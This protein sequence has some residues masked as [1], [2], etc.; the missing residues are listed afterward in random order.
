VFLTT[1]EVMAVLNLSRQTVTLMR[2][3]GV[4]A[5]YRQGVKHYCSEKEVYDLLEKRNQLVKLNR[6]DNHE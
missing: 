1:K 5:T 4:L 2:K 6:G 3:Q